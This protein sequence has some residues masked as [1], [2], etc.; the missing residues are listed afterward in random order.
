MQKNNVPLVIENV[1]TNYIEDLAEYKIDEKIWKQHI[2]PNRYF[3]G[4][5]DER[6]IFYKSVGCQSPASQAKPLFIYHMV[7]A[8]LNSIPL[9]DGQ[10]LQD[11]LAT[12]RLDFRL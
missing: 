4:I 1:T 12:R 11:V 8:P 7:Y 3:Y 5:T 9:E 6:V 2:S 10:T